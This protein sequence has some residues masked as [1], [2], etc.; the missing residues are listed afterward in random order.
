M[1]DKIKFLE[2][3]LSST[4]DTEILAISRTGIIA[5]DWPLMLPLFEWKINKILDSYYLKHGFIGPITQTFDSRK[6]LIF[7]L[8]ESYESD[9][10]FT[11]QRIAEILIDTSRQ[12]KVTHALMNALEK[13]L[14]VGSLLSRN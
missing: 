14:S 7:K 4:T 2:L 11:I 13:L 3:E 6:E 5:H 1:K 10:P 12:Y 9:A 8:L